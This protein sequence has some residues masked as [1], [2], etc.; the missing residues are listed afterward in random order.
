MLL[1]SESKL[2]I[3]AFLA[4]TIFAFMV[5]LFGHWK[6]EEAKLNNRVT[7]PTFF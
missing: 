1:G 4:A 7:K 2:E 5:T 6:L 3:N